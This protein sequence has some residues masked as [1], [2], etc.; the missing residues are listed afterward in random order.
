MIDLMVPDVPESL[1]MKIK[2][3]RYLAKQALADAG[4]LGTVSGEG[5]AGQGGK[6]MKKGMRE[7][8][9]KVGRREE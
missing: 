4:A 8:R 2:R 7:N 5:K 1:N 9:L 3:E 6:T